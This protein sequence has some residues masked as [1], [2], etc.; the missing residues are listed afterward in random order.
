MLIRKEHYYGDTVRK[1]FLA[2]A[3]FML[4][5]LPFMSTFLSVPIYVSILAAIAIGV[6]AGITNPLQVWV[7]I[8]NFILAV[9]AV[10]MFEYAAVNGYQ[11]YSLTHRTFWVNQILAINFLVALYYSTKTVR[12]MFL[13]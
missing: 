12:G 6:F 8:L 5:A 9:L 3:V 10:I 13:K 4:I 1:L 2:G 7:A 11:T